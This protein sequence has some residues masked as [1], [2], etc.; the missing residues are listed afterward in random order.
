LLLALEVEIMSVSTSTTPATLVDDAPYQL[1]DGVDAKEEDL[2]AF[3][4]HVKS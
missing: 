4:N 1:M 3:D 2:V